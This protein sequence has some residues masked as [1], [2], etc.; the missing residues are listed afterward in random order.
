MLGFHKKLW[1]GMLLLF[2]LSGPQELHGESETGRYELCAI[3]RYIV[4]K[5]KDIEG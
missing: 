3:L 1:S 2:L 4:D 5:K